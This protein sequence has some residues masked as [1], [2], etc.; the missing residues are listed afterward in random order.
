MIR[1]WRLRAILT[2]LTG[3]VL[4][5]G[6]SVAR[7]RTAA[8]LTLPAAYSVQTA[9]VSLPEHQADWRLFG[10][11]E[12]AELIAMANTGAFDLAAAMARVR[13][14]EA[15]ARIAGAPL[16]PQVD[17]TASAGRSRIDDD[18]A[19]SYGA[20]LSASYEIDV[21]GGNAAARDAALASLAATRYASDTVQLTLAASVATTWMQTVGA[22]ERTAI[23]RLNLE[24]AERVLALVDTRWRAGMATPLERAQQRG[25]VATQRQALA[26]REREARDAQAALALLVGRAPQ[27]LVVRTARLYAIASTAIAPGVPA[28]LLARRPDVAFAERALAA[29]DA[30]VAV[31][32]A[33]LLPRLTL[34]AGAGVGHDRIRG[35]FDNPLYNLAAGLTAPIFDAGRLSGARDFSLAQREELLADYRAAIVNAI[36]DVALALNAIDGLGHQRQAQDEAL[37]QAREAAR[38]AASRYR[39]GA[40]TLLTVLD[41]QRTLYAAQDD[42]AVLRLAQLQADVALFKAAGGDWRA[43]APPAAAVREAPASAADEPKDGPVADARSRSP[44]TR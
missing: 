23:A 41:A 21:W 29:A 28:D 7:D 1:A 34:T 26:A 31:A 9:A 25:L 22:R 33:A 11:A 19:S 2:S 37:T 16:L 32:R 40:E 18:T 27:D 10:N 38:L 44:A 42:A 8:S 39:F 15:Y 30:N 20:G 36:G 13:Q 35:L 12:L 5:A 17:A 6:C 3:M 43:G 24:A 14:A 4:L